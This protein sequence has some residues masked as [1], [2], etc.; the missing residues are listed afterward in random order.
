GSMSKPAVFLDRDN[1]LIRNDGDLGD[2]ERV[3]L[4][5]GVSSA[6]A[7][8]RGLGYRIVVVTNQ[9]GVARGKYGE[10]DVKA[11]HQRVAEMVEGGANGAR[12]DAFYYCPY[13]PQG[14][15][16]QYMREHPNRKP[17]PGMLLEAAADLD[18]DLGRSWMIGDQMRDV[19]AGA[20]AGCRTV[21][22]RADAAELS[23]LDLASAEGV[24][25]IEGDASA[26][27]VE[28]ATGVAVASAPV[29]PDFL[30]ASLIDAVRIVAQARQPET[31]ATP[32]P[33]TAGPVNVPRKWDAAAVAQLQRRSARPKPAAEP[34]EDEPTV[35][36]GRAKRS[37]TRPFRPW[38]VA[39]ED[40][41]A[42]STAE[43]ATAAT[44]TPPAPDTSV[45]A[46]PVTDLPGPIAAE[47]ARRRSVEAAPASHLP[48]AAPAE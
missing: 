5:Q 43:P 36:S 2:P 10:S 31:A 45:S 16:K 12:I 39:S 6:V 14:R 25:A 40:E 15:L 22:L 9:G 42:E 19:Q 27:A 17:S 21:L 32:E 20:A 18:L 29:K 8:L 24:R 4:I 38:G 47:L 41:N 28:E 46:E 11:V 34:S 7:S 3:E 1:T 26:G 23:P 33:G 13:H 48:Q 35:G 30:A 44:A 37:A